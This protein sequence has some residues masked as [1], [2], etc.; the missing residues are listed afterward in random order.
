MSRDCRL[1]VGLAA[2]LIVALLAPIRAQGQSCD[3]DLEVFGYIALHTTPPWCCYPCQG[4]PLTFW[5]P[6]GF[7]CDDGRP[8]TCQISHALVQE[9]TGFSIPFGVCSVSEAPN[10]SFCNQGAAANQCRADGGHPANSKNQVVGDPVDL[11]SGALERTEVDADLGGGLRFTRHYAS[12][13]VAVED[14]GLHWRHSLYWE[15]KRGVFPTGEDPGEWVTIKRP[16]RPPEIFIRRTPGAGPWQG[17]PFPTGSLS[18]DFSGALTY[19]SPEGTQV[20]FD[21]ADEVTSIR[22][23]GGVPIAATSGSNSTTYAN[24]LGALKLERDPSSGRILRLVANEGTT[25]EFEVVYEYVGSTLDNVT[26]PDFGS[27]TPGATMLLD[28]DYYTGGLL[29]EIKRTAR[30]GLE[31]VAAWQFNTST[32]QVTRAD[33][34]ALDQTLR[35]GY[36]AS[37][38][39]FDQTTVFD[40]GSTELAAVESSDGILKTAWGFAPGVELEVSATETEFGRWKTTTD[41]KGHVT[42]YDNHDDKGRH[43]RVVEAWVDGGT[44]GTPDGVFSTEDDYDR[45]TEY[46][47]H[48]RLNEPL[49]IT[50]ES[51]LTGQLEA[52]TTF[53]Y[54]DDEGAGYPNESPTDLVHA[55]IESGITLNESGGEEAFTF[56][57]RFTYNADG[58]VL[59]VTG[60]RPDNF[61]VHH[62]DAAG[63]RDWTHRYLNGSGSVYLETTFGSFDS[64][65]NPQTVTDPN[66]DVTMFTYD[67]LGRVAHVTPPFAGTGE[68]TID[69]MYDVDGRIDLITF[70][71]DSFGVTYS[72]DFGYSDDGKGDLRFIADS[73]GDAIVYTYDRGRRSRAA[74]YSNFT[75]DPDNPGT[76][77]GDAT[78][79]YGDIDGRLERAVNPLFGDNSIFTAFGHDANGNPTSVTDENGKADSLMYDALDRLKEVQQV[80][81]ATYTTAFAYDPQSNVSQVT[82]AAGKESDYRTDDLGRLVKV[83]S[84]DTGSTLFV[85]DEAG[86]LET[87]AEDFG[88]AAQRTARYEYDGLDRLTR[89]DLPSEPDWV[90]TYDSDAAKNQ[91]GR[92]AQASNG[93]VT[94]DLAYSD[95]GQLALEATT[96][97]G[98]RYEVAYTF[99]AA[100]NVATIQTP[101][102]T[103]LT[104]RYA[105]ARVAE[106]DVSSGG[107]TRTIRNLAWLPFG[108][109]THA[110]LPPYDS[111]TSHNVVTLQRQYNLRYQMT[112]LDVTAPTGTVLDRSYDY[113]YT[114]G[115]PGPSDPGPNLDQLVDHRDPDQSRFYFYDELDRLARVSDLLGS[116][117]FAYTYDAAGNRTFKSDT[118]GAT[119]YTYEAESD[120]LEA[121]TGAEQAFYAS[122]AYGSRIYEGAQPYA[123]TPS[124]T[125]NEQNRMVA[126][127][128]RVYDA[129]GRRVAMDAFRFLYDLSGRLLEVSIVAGGGGPA[130]GDLV[131]VEGEL[132]GR[133]ENDIAAGTPVGAPWILRGWR[134]PGLPGAGAGWAL[135]LGAGGS[136]VLLLGAR[137]RRS[138]RWVAAGGALIAIVVSG[139]ACVPTGL[140]FLWVHTDHLGVPIAMTNTPT[141]PAAAKVVWRAT[142][143]PFGLGLEELDPD[144]NGKS[145]RM[146]LRLPGQWWD[147]TTGLHDNF[148]RTYDPFTGRYLE[149]DP[150]GRMGELPTPGGLV[151]PTNEFFLRGNLYTYAV[152]DP[153]DYL[154]PRGLQVGGDDPY[155]KRLKD[156]A[157]RGDRDAIDE[158]KREV[159]ELRRKKKI[160]PERWRWIKAWIKM[161]RDGRILLQ[162]IIVP[163][164]AIWALCEQYPDEFGWMCDP[165]EPTASLEN[166]CPTG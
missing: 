139:L 1:P 44:E 104:Y 127:G 120:R 162:P 144:G 46:T 68:A 60:P 56:V 49:T 157:S 123:G 55:R 45:L 125:Y 113:A 17:G 140:A 10:F 61:T 9:Q 26:L 14:I 122:D 152:N 103:T 75:G 8:V 62:Y 146:P 29:K 50:R 94:T 131:W 28:Y 108:P 135:A 77:V 133:V 124:Y 63:H 117:L 161:A 166:A 2:A 109:L 72:L 99:D 36:G 106:V 71:E 69:F 11:A 107:Q 39:G 145:I 114:A 22:E 47:W 34:P 118:A 115:S 54:D 67:G 41:A 3:P 81:T 160:K 110:E 96:Y 27:P 159:D 66:G 65:G 15:A 24:A 33:E 156:A 165:E 85:Y 97:G 87:K 5:T 19:T 91:K 64:L 132:L 105:G 58:Q 59:T 128:T 4:Q 143:E 111:G 30:G 95:R 31:T 43:R 116:D 35:F 141:N 98:R 138:L 52:Q 13:S 16:L 134:G 57:T 83:T 149:A 90:F 32:K 164:P 48:P 129:F 163:L 136:V 112:E 101:M 153:I 80:R 137:R 84:P 92:L 126:P 21:A 18:G 150:I 151:E 155:Y 7:H 158:I 79:E 12:S 6:R 51:S 53:D 88:G 70:P 121:A 40:D 76:P 37:G 102:G 25:E 142:Y 89:I 119:S 78:F 74:L 23:P 154:D 38:S 20:V 82:D 42:L 93:V 86:N 147:Y 100:G 148:F 130:V 73:K